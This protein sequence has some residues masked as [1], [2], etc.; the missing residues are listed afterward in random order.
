MSVPVVEYSAVQRA[1]H[2][3]IKRGEPSDPEV[4]VIEHE[5]LFCNNLMAVKNA[6]LEAMCRI[7][8]KKDR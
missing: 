8:W 1:S 3:H 7:F 2:H 4:T 5:V 6:E